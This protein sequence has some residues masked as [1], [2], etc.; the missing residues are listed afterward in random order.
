M[1]SLRYGMYQGASS[2]LGI[3]YRREMNV[4]AALQIRLLQGRMRLS[5]NQNGFHVLLAH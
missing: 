4:L 1:V 3:S 5:S 2:F